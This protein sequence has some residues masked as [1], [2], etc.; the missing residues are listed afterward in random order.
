MTGK[1][2][3]VN[4]ALDDSVP[5]KHPLTIH[6]AKRYP[7]LAGGK[8]VHPI[9]SIASCELMIQTMSL[10]HDDFPCMDNDDLRRGHST[11]HIV[12]GE[13][14]TVLLLQAKLL[15]IESAGKEVNLKH[16]E[17]THV[18]KTAKLLEASVVCGAIIGV[19]NKMEVER[20]GGYARC[21]GLL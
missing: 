4:Q 14:T 10:I 16:L 11:N 2:K 17:Y 3:R 6:E 15:D 1:E 21:L 13:E 9:L 7:L 19:G 12:F 5:M 8:C 18:H 20:L